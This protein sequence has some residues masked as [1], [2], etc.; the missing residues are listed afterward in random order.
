[1]FKMKGKSEKHIRGIKKR[2]LEVLEGT[3]IKIIQKKISNKHNDSFWYDG[4]IAKVTKSNGTEL[5][6]IATGEIRIHN[7]EGEIV[8]DG[9]E[10]NEGIK[11]GLSN[12]SD[13]EKI[14][15]DRSDKYYWENNN[16]FE[17]IFKGKNDNSFDSVL[18]DVAHEYDGAIQ[19]LKD[20][21]EDE[22]Y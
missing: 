22:I 14:G 16:W 3:N 17:V 11:G 8:F 18:C 2:I 9:K 20:Y 4:E 5:C 15:D 13:L 6:L 12:D 10:R 1:M 19:L 21:I 7:K